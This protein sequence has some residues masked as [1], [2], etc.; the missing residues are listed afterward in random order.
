MALIG[1]AATIVIFLFEKKLKKKNTVSQICFIVSLAILMGWNETIADTEIYQIRY[2]E[3][4]TWLVDNSQPAMFLFMFLCNK[5]GLSFLQFKVVFLAFGLFLIDSARKKVANGQAHLF[6][7]LYFIYPMMIDAAQLKNFMAMAFVS[8]AIVLLAKDGWIHKVG[9][10]ILTL[11]AAGFQI[12]AFAYLPLVVFV[13]SAFKKRYRILS[14]L[15]I[16]GFAL[17]FSNKITSR[18]LSNYLL[19]VLKGDVLDRT[20]RFLTAST[21]HGYIVYILA[22]VVVF[23]F[24]KW[25]KKTVCMRA[26]A[27]NFQKRFTNVVYLCSIYAFLFIPFYFYRQDFSRLL[28]NFAIVNHFAVMLA[29]FCTMQD[30]K[31]HNIKRRSFTLCR[32]ESIFVGYLI[33]LAYIFYWDIGVYMDTVVTPFFENII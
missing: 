32:T 18:H 29:M 33:Y 12:T 15:P 24:A 31:L 1:F 25:T 17:L 9:F 22:T 5:I 13:N 6:W 19:T 8:Y 26:S 10:V 20:E 27:T 23:G 4:K 21:N 11:I 28:R 2:S 7:L 14:C 3:A 16:L 30:R